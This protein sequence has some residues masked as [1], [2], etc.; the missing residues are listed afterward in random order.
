MLSDEQELAL[1]SW[2]QEAADEA[3]DDKEKDKAAAGAFA[4]YLKTLARLDQ[5][6]RGKNVE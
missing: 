6:K 4:A 3:Y 1:H 5:I 2:L